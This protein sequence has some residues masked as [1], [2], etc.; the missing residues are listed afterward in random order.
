MDVFE[1]VWY[2][3]TYII[4]NGFFPAKLKVSPKCLIG[5]T[6]IVT[7]G[8]SGIGYATATALASR[9]CRVILADCQSGTKAKNEIIA[10][11]GNQN[12]VY[13]HLDLG[14]F[15]SVR[16]FA[17]D[18]CKTE[19]K[20]DIL[21]N[22]AA[23]GITE[24]LLSEDGLNYLMQVN[25]FGAFLLTHLLLEPLKKA[26]SGRV[27]FIG[28]FLAS[29]NNL[30]LD[31]LNITD[32]EMTDEYKR[33]LYSHS[34]TCCIITAQEFAKRLKNYGITVNSLDPTAVNTPMVQNASKNYGNLLES[35]IL[36]F[37]SICFSKDV[38]VVANFYLSVMTKEDADKTNGEY[39]VLSKISRK[40]PNVDNEK[41]CQALWTQ[42][43]EYVLLKPEEKISS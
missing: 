15:R 21:L 13:K 36:T 24:K 31:N 10:T 1:R 42:M 18:I 11:T 34:K 2:I 41:L 4:N 25:V 12:V 37:L 20:I 22:N 35:T 9:G 27:F 29:I 3:I 33:L 38:D 30:S 40:P 39:Y 43:E 16:N 8:C 14:S 26:E 23:V 28:S 19:E 6:A 7:G 17:A 32:Y 5:K